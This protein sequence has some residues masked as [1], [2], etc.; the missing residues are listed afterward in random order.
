MKVAILGGGPS[1]A[2]AAER[3]AAAGVD[4]K[5][6]SMKS[7]RGKSPAAAASPGRPIRSIRFCSRTVPLKRPS[8]GPYW[9]HRRVSPS[10]SKLDHP[11][12]IY[13]RYD[14]NGLLLERAQIAGARIE[15]TRVLDMERKGARWS[16]RTQTGTM[17]V[18]Y[19]ILATG[20]RNPLRG[21]GTELKSGDTMKRAGL[22]R[23]GTAR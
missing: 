8:A 5:L 23:C 7:S 17:E 16:L 14:L 1:G 6:S 11:L 20:A 13:S 12:L 18:D 22:L 21:F 2:F 9:Q 10:R 19:C 4:T 15:K 3:L